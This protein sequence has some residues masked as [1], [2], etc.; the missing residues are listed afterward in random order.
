M[1]RIIRMGHPI[2]FAVVLLLT[3]AAFAQNADVGTPPPAAVGTNG[4][5]IREGNVWDH[6]AHQPTQAEVGGASQQTEQQVEQ[7]VKDLLQQTDRLDQQSQQEE[8]GFSGSS[9]E[10]H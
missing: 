10:R 4:V 1:P 7:S 3:G 8:E 9:V 2:V 5:P 6:L